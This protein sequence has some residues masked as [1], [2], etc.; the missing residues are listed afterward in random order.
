MKLVFF[1]GGLANQVFQYIF[2]RLGQLR[3]PEEEMVRLLEANYATN[4]NPFNGK[5]C[6]PMVQTG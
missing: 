4:W 2:Y 1:N 5:K 3:H 6:L